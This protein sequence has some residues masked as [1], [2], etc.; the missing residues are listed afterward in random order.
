MAP[1]TPRSLRDRFFAH[2]FFRGRL[3]RY[4][5]YPGRIARYRGI[6]RHV[7]DD[8]RTRAY[9]DSVADIDIADHQRANTNI[10]VIADTRR[11]SGDAAR[12][13]RRA[14]TDTGAQ[15]TV[16]PN[17]D[18]RM[19]DDIVSVI[20]PQSRPSTHIGMNL[21]TKHPTG[22]HTIRT[23]DNPLNQP[24][25]RCLPPPAQIRKPIPGQQHLRLPLRI[26]T[27]ILKHT[28]PKRQLAH[29]T[30]ERPLLRSKDSRNSLARTAGT[31]T[32]RSRAPCRLESTTASPVGLPASSTRARG[33][34]TCERS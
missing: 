20:H 14:N 18:V 16:A 15:N 21:G 30:P 8:D 32:I 13:D 7:L 9:P 19:K 10:D 28:L 23:I 25:K 22:R 31:P 12:S 6:R 5:K 34:D 2:E 1:E 29:T 3:S 4:W 33:V 27:P 11:W 17:H 26:A 24:W